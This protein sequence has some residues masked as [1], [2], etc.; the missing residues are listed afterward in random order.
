MITIVEVIDE[1]VTEEEIREIKE[2][3]LDD[4]LRSIAIKYCTIPRL[5]VGVS[6]VSQQKATAIQECSDI[7]NLS[8]KCCAILLM[9]SNE[10]KYQL[11]ETNNLRERM[12]TCITLLKKEIEI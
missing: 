6:S 3:M 12:E 8:F 10:N 7:V 5:G 4:S 2:S 9:T 1:A 11:L